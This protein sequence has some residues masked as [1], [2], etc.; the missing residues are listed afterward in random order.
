MR[1][2]LSPRLLEAALWALA[3]WLDTYVLPAEPLHAD[4]APQLPD[5]GAVLRT[6]LEA[7]AA[8]VMS[9]PGEVELHTVVVRTLL[10]TLVK[11]P[12]RSGAVAIMPAWRELCHAFAS[13]GFSGPMARMHS[14]LQRKLTQAICSTLARR[15]GGHAPDGATH[16]SSQGGCEAELLEL[17]RAP[18][19]LV[20]RFG[21]SE[22]GKVP[23]AMA[24]VVGSASVVRASTSPRWPSAFNLLA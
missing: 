4:S 6:A 24:A 23:A 15:G 19:E 3:R 14:K 12:A 13:Q 7:S 1:A 18:L 10:H 16:G 9:Y 20:G 22:G 17:L 11:Q 2:R 8:C 5:A 21:G